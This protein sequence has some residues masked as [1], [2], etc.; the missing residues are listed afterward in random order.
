V[1]EWKPFAFEDDFSLVCVL[2]LC[3][4]LTPS[5]LGN[6]AML[7][8]NTSVEL[9]LCILL[10][11]TSASRCLSSSCTSKLVNLGLSLLPVFVGIVRTVK[12]AAFFFT[13]ATASGCTMPG[14]QSASTCR[15]LEHKR[16]AILLE[17]AIPKLLHHGLCRRANASLRRRRNEA[18]HDRARSSGLP[19]VVVVDAAACISLL[20]AVPWEKA[21]KDAFGFTCAGS[22]CVVK[23]DFP[24][25]TL[26]D[27][28]WIGVEAVRRV[29]EEEPPVRSNPGVCDD[30]EDAL[31]VN[32]RR[33]FVL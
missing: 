5:S 9:E 19:H 28:G 20:G 11:R 15:R 12:L 14:S 10:E 13:H 25:F 31:L 4:P 27:V 16:L 22:D 21:S 8:L 33:H 6:T 2:L 1:A 29:D 32:R 24:E 18:A 23:D 17:E 26:G 3:P 7:G 30:Q